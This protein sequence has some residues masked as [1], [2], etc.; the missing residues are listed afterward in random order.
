MNTTAK[1]TCTCTCS[2]CSCSSRKRRLL[3]K[4]VDIVID[5]N[6][7]SLLNKPLSK[8][9][10]KKAI[11]KHKIS[12]GYIAGEGDSFDKAESFPDKLILSVPVKYISDVSGKKKVRRVMVKAIREEEYYHCYCQC[13]CGYCN[14]E[15]RIVYEIL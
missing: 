4:K 2:C 3:V 5:C 13:G 12:I 15:C 9:E 8:R 1:K 14:P 6:D 7:I 11:K 10:V